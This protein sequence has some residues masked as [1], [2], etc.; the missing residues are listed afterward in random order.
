MVVR[1]N[2]TKKQIEA[3]L[4]AIRKKQK[5]VVK[6]VTKPVK[7]KSKH[8]DEGWSLAGFSEIIER[9]GRE[10]REKD[11][12][13][14]EDLI[15][16]T[17]S[18]KREIRNMSDKKLINFIAEYRGFSDPRF[19]SHFDMLKRYAKKEAIARMANGHGG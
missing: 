15:N 13:D 7:A 11:D 6:A 14:F 3:L 17:R 8:G 10:K 5:T 2:A 16:R 4:P 19:T 9:Q 1:V 18:D 12:R